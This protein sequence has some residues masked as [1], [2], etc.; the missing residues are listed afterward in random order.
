MVNKFYKQEKDGARAKRGEYV[1]ALRY[2]GNII[3]ALRIQPMHEEWFLRS[4]LVSSNYQRQG[5]GKR[6]LSTVFQDFLTLNECHKNETSCLEKFSL[7]GEPFQER[8]CFC[9]PYVHLVSFY[10]SVGFYCV[11]L[12]NELMFIQQAFTRYTNQGRDITVMRVGY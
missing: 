11:P 8:T 12:S 9:F 4:M 6:F 5:L 2:C 1:Y 3:G 7:V 10:H